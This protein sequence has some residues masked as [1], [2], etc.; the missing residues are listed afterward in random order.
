MTTLSSRP[1][2]V[3]LFACSFLCGPTRAVG[4]QSGM[5]MPDLD[6][7]PVVAYPSMTARCAALYEEAARLYGL[8]KRFVDARDARESAANARAAL[9]HLLRSAAT[10]ADGARTPNPHQLSYEAAALIRDA[11]QS[12]YRLTPAGTDP[13]G[14]RF[15]AE[16]K[17]CDE[18]NVLRQLIE[19]AGSGAQSPTPAAPAARASQ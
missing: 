12:V 10:S 4:Q 17:A 1:I 5:I 6:R 3:L 15:W 16:V 11:K 19:A 14:D 7:M 9:V 13:T 2:G 18:S 8:D